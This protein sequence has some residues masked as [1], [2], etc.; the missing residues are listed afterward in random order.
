MNRI[1]GAILMIMAVF[2]SG[3]AAAE[4]MPKQLV[5]ISGEAVQTADWSGKV[6]LFVNVASKCGFTGQY[7]GLQKLWTDYKERGLVVVG[8]PCNQF[9]SQEPGKEAEI[10]SFCRMNYGVD[11][12]LLEK[13]NVN[14][15]KRSDLYR[16]LGKG[17]TPVLWNFEKYVVG[18]DGKVVDRFRSSTGPDD[19]D[20]I[21][22]IEKALGA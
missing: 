16:F 3:Q 19:K 1:A 8:V 9:G 14:G 21:A 4:A 13:Q 10:Q 18:R 22:A 12:P 7:D 6:L 17:K 5:G 15:S 2:G 11:F 20:L